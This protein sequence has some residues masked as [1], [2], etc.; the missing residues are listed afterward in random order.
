MRFLP[1]VVL[2]AA[3]TATPAPTG[4]GPVTL[5]HA[6]PSIDLA[7]GEER[8]NLCQ[9]WT[10]DNDQPINVNTVSLSSGPAWHHSNWTFVPDDLYPGPDGVWPCDDRNYDEA[11]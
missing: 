2:L 3:C 5:E 8:I 9:S 11:S 10:L 7:G 4:N 6:F 1:A